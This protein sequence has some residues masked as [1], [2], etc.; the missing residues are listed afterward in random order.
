MEVKNKDY[1]YGLA[2]ELARDELSHTD[3][4]GQC[5]RSG[6]EHLPDQKAV[7]VEFVS[8]PYQISLPGGEVTRDGQE[9]PV[10]EKILVLHYFLQAKDVPLT[11][12]LIS[13]KE[14]PEGSGY[15]PTFYARAI[16][17]LVKQF[18]REPGRLSEV[19]RILGGRPAS[20]GDVSVTIDGFRKVPVTLVLWRGDDEFP[21][22][23]NILLDSS[24]SHYLP[25]EDIIFLCQTITWRLAKASGEPVQKL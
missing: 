3:I 11:N 23:G 19:A 6:A 24:I 9:A 25:A 1:G 10:P 15:Y 17:P 22:E 18:G 4:A 5:R 13:F 8:Q 12:D 2:L 21:P 7:V 14:L 16:K 20:Y